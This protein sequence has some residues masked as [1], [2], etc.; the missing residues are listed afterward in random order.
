ML[1]PQMIAIASVQ[2]IT[3]SA[4]VFFLI[5]VSPLSLRTEGNKNLRNFESHGFDFFPPCRCQMRKFATSLRHLSILF[6]NL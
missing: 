6:N 1:S 4:V 2:S 3:S 5:V